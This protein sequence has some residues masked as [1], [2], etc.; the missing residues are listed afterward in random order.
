MRL[1]VTGTAE[2]L[3]VGVYPS[4]FHVAWTPPPDL[5]PRAPASS[6]PYIGSLAVDVEPVVF[7]DGN[8]PT[9]TSL[10]HAWVDAVGF[11]E[12]K[13][14]SVR[15]GHNGP[16]GAGLNERILTPLGLTADSVA[17][18]DAVPWFFVKPGRGGQLDA[19]ENRF[20]PIATELDIRPGS[21]PRR[22]SARRLPEIAATEPRRNALRNEILA[23]GAPVIIT[24]GQEALDALIGVA[25]ELGGTQ[26]RLAPDGYGAAGEVIVDGR[27]L[28]V[29]PLAHP[30]FIRQTKRRDWL[31]ALTSWELHPSGT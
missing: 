12:N 3:V 5:D 29:L 13:H 20:R 27:R 4:A 1:P 28:T 16:S 15:P 25:D 8:N 11:I 18:T 23:A 6:R 14:G 9:P 26:R 2:A 30:G 7:W 31:D 24:L 19:I 17:F 10:L 21:L 22:P